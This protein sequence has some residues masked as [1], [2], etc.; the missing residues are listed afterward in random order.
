[1]QY[2]INNNEYNSKTESLS[3]SQAIADLDIE[4]KGI[5]IAINETIISKTA[6]NNTAINNGDK[7]IIIKAVCGG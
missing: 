3:L 1:M 5:A 4:T 7:I 6:W 2:Y